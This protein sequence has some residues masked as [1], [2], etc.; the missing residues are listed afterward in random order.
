MEYSL[1]ILAFSILK[2]YFSVYRL[3]TRFSP[4][5]VNV[6]NLYDLTMKVLGKKNSVVVVLM[7]YSFESNVKHAF[8]SNLW[9]QSLKTEIHSIS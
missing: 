2:S 4:T 7:F 8:V 5:S 6:L 9:T 1:C 3:Y